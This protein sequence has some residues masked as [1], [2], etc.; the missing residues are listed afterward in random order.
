MQNYLENLDTVYTGTHFT[1][2]IISVSRAIIISIEMIIKNYYLTINVSQHLERWHHQ[3]LVSIQNNQ[4]CNSLL[5]KTEG[6]F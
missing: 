2:S 5:M 1:F 4:N 3:V 6:H